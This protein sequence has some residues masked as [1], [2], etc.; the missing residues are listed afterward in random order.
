MSQ[1]LEIKSLD[2]PDHKL[3]F[4]E[5]KQSTEAKET[6]AWIRTKVEEVRSSANRISH[7]GIWN[8]NIAYLWASMV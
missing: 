8:D 4:E 1:G 3:N 6:S 5:L 2:T 7:E